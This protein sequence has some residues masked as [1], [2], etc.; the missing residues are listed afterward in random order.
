MAEDMEKHIDYIIP[1]DNRE[2]QRVPSRLEQCL[3]Y[4]IPSDNRE[5]QPTPLQQI[6]TFYYII[7]SDNRE[8][9][10]SCVRYSTQSI[11]SYQVI[12]GNY[13]TA[14]PLDIVVN[15]IS[16]QVITGNYNFVR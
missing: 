1:S 3:Y 16:Y 9:Q 11:I 8:L 12:T 15:I 13:N 6:A 5:L 7:P 14:L 2:L 10:R 4:I